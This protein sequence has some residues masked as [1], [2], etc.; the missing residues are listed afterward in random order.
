[1][2]SRAAWASAGFW[3]RIALRVAIRVSVRALRISETATM[4]VTLSSYIDWAPAADV[5]S[6]E[7]PSRPTV[8]ATTAATSTAARTLV[9][10]RRS[11]HHARLRTG[12]A[13]VGWG[14]VRLLASADSP[15]GCVENDAGIPGDRRNRRGA[16]G[17]VRT[18]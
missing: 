1:M 8:I 2:L 16:C 13:S 9:R 7:R 17:A 11:P 18:I 12:S 15:S 14:M 3:A 5:D 4:V 10:T 6:A